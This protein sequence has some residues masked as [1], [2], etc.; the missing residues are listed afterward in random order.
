MTRTRSELRTTQ[1]ARCEAL[2][3]R[4]ETAEA[5][6]AELQALIDAADAALDA[7]GV[8]TMVKPGLDATTLAERIEELA[9][10]RNAADEGRR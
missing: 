6:I 8:F 7:A 9:E 5:R 10:S 4:A 1:A 3:R 2:L